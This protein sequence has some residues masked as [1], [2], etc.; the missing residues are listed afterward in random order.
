MEK[1]VI[2]GGR[3]LTGRVHVEGSK[4]AALP[5]QAA[6][7]LATVGSFRLTNVPPLLDIITMNRLLKF[8][9]VT[10]VFDQEK[11]ELLLDAQKDVAN[12]APFEYV[13]EMRASMLVLGPLL[14]RTGYAKVA[15]PGGCAIGSRPIDLHIKG[16]TALG[17]Q[18][19]Q[20]DGYIVAQADRLTA[21]R[22]YLDFP[23]VGATE[24]LMMAATRATGITTIE[25]AAR[26]PE[27][28]E[29]ANFLNKM[30]ARVHGAGTAVIRIQGVTF[31]HGCEYQLISDR[32]E[33]GTFM[34][35]AAITNGDVLVADAVAEHN[36]SLI[37]KLEEMGVTVVRQDNGIRVLGTSV[38]LPTNIKTMPYPGF[39]TDLQPQISVLQLLANGI[40][41]LDE[42]IFEKRFMHLEELRRMN[43]KFQISGP[44]AVLDGPTRFSGAEVTASDLRAGAALVLAGLA[45]TGITQVRNVSEIDRGYYRFQQKLRALGAQ[46]DRI[47][48]ADKFKLSPGHPTNETNH[49]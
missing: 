34:I 3:R 38:L 21:A 43:A 47:D 31:L 37:A 46:I 10:V 7:L 11:H 22:I 29:L 13:D 16:L 18:V 49:D 19:D 8:L 1:M 39:P 17:A 24:D 30:G 25:N 33:A 26:E 32:I 27:I 9:N 48:I 6:S 35:A 2:K 36:A 4:N 23:S 45:A 14:A 15:L 42:R 12:E 28:I 40:S 41:T 44:V 5:I 20:R